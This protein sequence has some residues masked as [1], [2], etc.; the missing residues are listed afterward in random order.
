MSGKVFAGAIIVVA[1]RWTDRLV[2]L[3]STLVL[4]RLLVPDDFG[5]IA[6]ASVYAGLI[7]VFLDLGVVAA[8]IHKGQ[9]DDD[10]YSTA[11]TIRMVQGAVAAMIIFAT[12]PLVADYYKDPRV[13]GVLYVMAGTIVIAGLENIGI[14]AFQKN[15]QFGRDFQ[16][17]FLRRI[18]GFVVTLALAWHLKS[19]W[20]LPIGALIGRA[21][22][23]GLS[24]MMHPLRPRLTLQKMSGIW[25]MSQWMLVRNVGVY[26]DSRLD[27]L[28]VGGRA[29]ASTV[30]AY[31][32]AD[33]ISTMPTT[34]LLAPLG[35][36]LF[37][38]FVEARDKPELLQR[39]FLLA[40]SVQV[41]IAF[42]A[43]TG[44]ALVAKD[45]VLVLLGDRWSIAVPFVQVLSL[46][47]GISAVSH[48]SGYLL[49]TLG[50]IRHMAIFIWVQVAIFALG[51]FTVFLDA[52]PIV[53][54]QWRLVVTACSVFGFISMV[55]MNVKTLSAKDIVNAAWRPPLAVAMMAGL[56]WL[57]PW[58][59]LSPVAS[60]VLQCG[61]G[62]L[63]YTV[64]LAI[65]WFVSGRPD[66]GEAYVLRKLMPLLRRST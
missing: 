54:A 15:M 3:V 30:G 61:L 57:M 51:V 2:G 63:S 9:C 46:I 27:K 28:I 48:A 7:D 66:G 65:L 36:V 4:A 10:D 60:L 55:L 64:F 24:Y 22:G 12:A 29:D 13:V 50:K 18:I 32:L 39:S 56:L 47:Y 40:L 19:Y 62:G 38:A 23:V 11:W 5:V 34:E 42:P 6:M 26:F 25:S 20:A 44:L 41:I 17:F 1:M 58:H 59:G 16:F 43:A 45:A 21:A 35:R 49:L 8:L 14:V 52:S 37:P 53:I 33:E 31:S